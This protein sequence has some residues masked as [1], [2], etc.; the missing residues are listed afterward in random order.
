MGRL[1]MRAQ[2]NQEFLRWRNEID[3]N[4]EI[5]DPLYQCLQG[6][7]LRRWWKRLWVV[8]E[9]AL[10]SSAL[11]V[12]GSAT[13][14]FS[15]LDQIHYCILEERSDASLRAYSFLSQAMVQ[16][17]T[18]KFLNDD[19]KRSNVMFARL[20]LHFL[21]VSSQKEASDPRDK[22]FGIF[23]LVNRFGQIFPAPDYNKSV[24]T[25]FT[26]AAKA[27]ITFTKSSEILSY[28]SGESGQPDLPSWAPDWSF[29]QRRHISPGWFNAN[30]G[31]EAIYELSLNSIALR[32]KGILVKNVRE[33]ADAD[34][35]PEPF[36]R[37]KVYDCICVWQQWS[38]LACSLAQYS[39]S[40]DLQETLWRTLCWDSTEI[41]ERPAS[42]DYKHKFD[43]W[44][45]IL[46]SSDRMPTEIGNDLLANHN[47]MQFADEVSIWNSQRAL[48]ITTD[49]CMA[50]VPAKAR[51]NDQIAI[52]S[53]SRLPFV[54]RPTSDYIL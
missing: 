39:S 11:L 10:A 22:V 2:L 25:V 14:D 1:S 3:Q 7:F 27:L 47:A 52:L 29:I 18:R 42:L 30:N 40:E 35:R 53:G 21:Y 13:L 46:L 28:S 43:A 41:N 17:S 16:L 37:P 6:I 5:V 38:R 31:L 26:E 44:H 32:I 51:P 23:G 15:D 33:V 50:M 19:Y 4:T 9:A 48:C 54:I 20:A 8:Q 49:R 45:H 34:Q 12:C 24:G 36:A